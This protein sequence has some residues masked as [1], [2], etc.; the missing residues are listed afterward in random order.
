M[1]DRNEAYHCVRRE[2]MFVRVRADGPGNTGTWKTDPSIDTVP[3][4]G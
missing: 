1:K 3:L 2:L 4:T